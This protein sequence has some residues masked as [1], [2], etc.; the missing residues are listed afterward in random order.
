LYQSGLFDVYPFLHWFPDLIPLV[1]AMPFGPLFYFYA[2]SVT[3]SSF[4]LTPKERWQFAPVIIDIVPNIIVWVFV[5]GVLGKMLNPA[6]GRGW[7]D[8]IDEYNAY[9][10]IPRWI[11]MTTYVWLCRKYL[12]S[13][14]TSVNHGKDKGNYKWLVHFFNFMTGFQVLWFIFLVPYIIPQLR[15]PFLDTVG[16]YPLYIPIV[17]MVYWFGIRG[18]IYSQTNLLRNTAGTGFSQEVV[19]KT[20]EALTKSMNTDKLYRDPGL[21]VTQ[22]STTLKIPQKTISGVVNQHLK[23]SFNEYINGFRIAEVK[24]RLTG[25]GNEHYTIT[26]IAFDCG[27][28]SQAT[29]QRAFKSITHLSPSE[30]LEQ[31]RKHL[32]KISL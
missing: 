28:N 6:S 18:Y 3:D 24:Q 19:D 31:Q 2:K 9:S 15:Y 20:I 27:F 22:L 5:I 10:D 11:S 4:R 12:N 8:F 30:F 26:G 23:K 7:G 25:A 29:F 17:V 13:V 14:I 21:T 16:W 32:E 1:V